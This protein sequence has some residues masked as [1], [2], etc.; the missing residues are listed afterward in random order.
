M[1][2]A[3][4]LHSSQEEWSFFNGGI[5]VHNP[6]QQVNETRAAAVQLMEQAIAYLLAQGVPDQ[7]AVTRVR[8]NFERLNLH[9]IAPIT[10]E[11][12]CQ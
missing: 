2:N 5:E 8:A 9:S 1:V 3:Y 6:F 11:A 12:L 7:E 4:A 10:L